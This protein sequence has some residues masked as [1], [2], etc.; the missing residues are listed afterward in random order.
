MTITILVAMAVFTV[1][2]LI[3]VALLL[4]IKTRLTPKGTVKILSLIHI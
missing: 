4:F 1:V 3:L 2:T